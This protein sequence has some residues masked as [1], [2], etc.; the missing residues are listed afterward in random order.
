[1][2]HFCLVYYV[3]PTSEAE[4]PC[5]D[6]CALCFA[7]D[8]FCQ[9]GS[10]F[11]RLQLCIFKCDVRRSLGPWRLLKLPSW[12]VEK[13]HFILRDTELCN[14]HKNALKWSHLKQQHEL[15]VYV[16]VNLQHQTW[17]LLQNLKFPW[18]DVLFSISSCCYGRLQPPGSSAGFSD[19]HVQ[20]FNLKC[21]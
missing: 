2:S 17:W 10:V 13:Q 6:I 1:M 3:P 7:L 19:Y 11:W 4:A 16:S 15:L 8:T 12:H 14:E 18:C 21:K 5:P 9:V 20:L